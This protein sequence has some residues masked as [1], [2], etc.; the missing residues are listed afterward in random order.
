MQANN[1]TRGRSSRFPNKLYEMVENAE[2]QGYDHIVSWIIDEKGKH[3][4]AIHDTDLLSEQVLS[5]YFDSSNFRSLQRQL[6]YW[7]FERLTSVDKKKEKTYG[8]PSGLFRKG[9]KTLVDAIK[10]KENKKSCTRKQGI[11]INLKHSVTEANYALQA[12]EETAEGMAWNYMQGVRVNYE[13]R[14]KDDKTASSSMEGAAAQPHDLLLVGE[15]HPNTIIPQVQ[16]DEVEVEYARHADVV[17]LDENKCTAAELFDDE[18]EQEEISG[19]ANN[20]SNYV[21]TN[22]N[23]S[24][25]YYGATGGCHRVSTASPSVSSM[26]S[27]DDDEQRSSSSSS[28][29][30]QQPAADSENCPAIHQTAAVC[31]PQQQNGIISFEEGRTFLSSLQKQVEDFMKK[32]SSA[33]HHQQPT[34]PSTRQQPTEDTPRRK[35]EEEEEDSPVPAAVTMALH[36]TLN[37]VYCSLQQAEREILS[38]LRYMES[39]TSG[40]ARIEMEALP[41]VPAPRL[42]HHY[43]GPRTRPR[44]DPTTIH[45]PARIHDYQQQQGQ[46]SENL[47]RTL[48][49]AATCGEQGELLEPLS[50]KEDN[51]DYSTTI[52]Q[53]F[54]AAVLLYMLNSGNAAT[55]RME[56]V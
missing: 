12:L 21:S 13:E 53:A 50:A 10:R 37:S 4:F 32:S 15:A 40:N 48:P 23:A 34:G 35:E 38:G 6:S 25:D 8:H 47:T 2:R 11:S 31:W 52:D 33:T 27:C 55:A 56:A 1:K 45:V 3:G 19:G 20:N 9:E 41:A 24:S 22:K 42:L 5:K 54:P 17:A 51:D 26:T 44:Q 18:D 16:Q 36:Q 49:P 7:S 39:R 14:S 43:Q 46:H 28:H 29:H 30:V